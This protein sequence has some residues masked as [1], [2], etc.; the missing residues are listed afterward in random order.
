MC[1]RQGSSTMDEF[2]Q[3]LDQRIQSMAVAHALLSQVNW[4][5]IRVA[6]I[7]RHQLA[8]YAT[9][10]NTTTCGSDVALTAAATEALAMV[11]HELVTNASKYGA[12]SVP[13]G[14]VSVG[15]ECRNSGDA[16]AVL[17]LV[18]RE[19]GSISI[20]VRNEPHLQTHPSRARWCG[21]PRVFIR[22][23]VLHNRDSSQGGYS[24]RRLREPLIDPSAGQ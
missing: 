13:E 12:L 17:I 18:W 4:L 11:R 10:A 22:W 2:V 15:W 7:V 9:K 19:T 23:R 21:R 1:T 3:A 8:A 5:G 24:R 20:R 6:D 14:R 16:A